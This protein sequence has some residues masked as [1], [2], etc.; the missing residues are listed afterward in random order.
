MQKKRNIRLIIILIAVMLATVVIHFITR[1]EDKLKVSRDIFSYE[2]PSAVDK[3][4]FSAQAG[5]HQLSFNGSEWQ[6]GEEYKADPQRVSVLFAILKQMRV[7]RKVSKQ[8]EEEIAN[9]LREE[10][11]KVR[12]YEGD[13]VGHEFYVWGDKESSMTYLAKSPDE[14]AYI[15]EIPGYRSFLAGIFQLDKSGWRDPL[16]FTLNWSNLSNVQVTYPQKEELGFTIQYDDRFY[17]IAE[18]SE[19]D[20]SKLTDF[21]DDVS[22]LYANDFLNQEEKQKY[23]EIINSQPQMS[24]KVEDVGKNAYTLE[25]YDMLPDGKEIIGRIDSADYAVFD[26]SKVRK[27]MRPRSFFIKKETADIK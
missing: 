3:V 6:I 10:G 17:S 13:Q 11:T 21:L 2:D 16:V 25:I 15:V 12:F 4:V 18:I 24:I 1:P 7:R 27:I 22:L 14:Q 5:E 26:V 9:K 8:Q 19:T 20:S 23:G